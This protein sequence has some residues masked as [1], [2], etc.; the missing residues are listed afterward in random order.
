MFD[1]LVIG[2]GSGGVRASRWAAQLGAKVA[3]VEER[4]LGGTCV[5]VGCVPKKMLTYAAEINQQ[6][7]LAKSYG[8]TQSNQLDWGSLRDNKTKEISRLN[9]I[10]EKLLKNAGVTLIEGHARVVEVGEI[11]KVEVGNTL[12]RAKRLLIATGGKPF[13]PPVEGAELA[14]ISDDLFYLPEL[15]R[16]AVVIGGGYIACEFASI[17]NGLG[18]K[19]T[20]VYRGEQILRGFDNDIRQ[21]VAEQMQRQGI[22]IRVKTDV[23]RI[24]KGDIS[25]ADGSTL[26][27]DKVF[28]ATGRRPNLSNL[29]AEGCEPALT[30]QGFI[31]VGSSFETNLSGVYAVGDVIG[32]LELTPVALAEGM[33]L[34]NELFGQKNAAPMDYEAIPTAV[35][36]QP[37]VATVGLTQEDALQHYGRLRIYKSN[38][39]PLRYTLGDVQERTL[40]KLVVDDAT[41]KVVGVH[42]AGDY[43]AETVQGLAIPLKMGATKADFDQV[44]GIHP[45]SA[46]EWVT[47]RQGELVSPS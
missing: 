46:E 4:F 25:L 35:F 47:M 6:Q 34:A 36:C 11:K 18:V 33:W 32:N 30:S 7:L 10:Y 40:M 38:F 26:K 29:F 8:I 23:T 45:T 17:L 28:F 13:V 15:P 24:T 5:N 44:I 39:R 22:D 43:A 31:E 2:A 21:F 20:Q 14:A 37:N 9:G 1:L 41:D 16:Q 42:M 12:Y 19:V 3:I 27:T